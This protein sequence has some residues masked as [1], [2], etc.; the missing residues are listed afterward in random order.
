MLFPSGRSFSSSSSSSFPF[1]KLGSAELLL[2]SLPSYVRSHLFWGIIRTYRDGTVLVRNHDKWLLR[3]SAD[4]W[5]MLCFQYYGEWESFYVIDRQKLRGATVLDV[6]A[7]C[8]ETAAFYFEKGAKKVICVESDPKCLCLLDF[9]KFLN[10]WN[11]DIVRGAFDISILGRSEIQ[12]AKFDCEACERALLDLS[13]SDV[14]F[15]MVG[16]IHD[17]AILEEREQ[18]GYR[19]TIPLVSFLPSS[20][21]AVSRSPCRAGDSPLPLQRFLLEAHRRCNPPSRD[22][23]G[24]SRKSWCSPQEVRRV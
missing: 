20:L 16:E 8:G 7:G 13:T 6:G 18:Q 17:V 5:R 4:Y 15:D 9:N 19:Q 22:L 10:E 3:V 1:A 11:S 2:S 12:F 24:R 23:R 14:H 21:A